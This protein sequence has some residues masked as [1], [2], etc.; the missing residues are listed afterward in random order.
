[1]KVARCL[2]SAI[3][4]FPLLSHGAA[5]AQPVVDGSALSRDLAAVIEFVRARLAE[6]HTQTC[7]FGAPSFDVCNDVRTADLRNWYRDE[8][9]VWELSP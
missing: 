7:L 5:S 3:L 1:M 9:F 8:C 6:C 2:S 4:L